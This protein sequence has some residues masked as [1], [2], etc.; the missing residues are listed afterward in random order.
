MIV[1]PAGALKAAT[2]EANIG[3]QVRLVGD[4]EGFRLEA[5]NDE[6][7]VVSAVLKHNPCDVLDCEVDREMLGKVA[8]TLK[9]DVKLT[10]TLSAVTLTVGTGKF[11]LSVLQPIPHP[12]YEPVKAGET[13]MLAHDE[14]VWVCDNLGT[15]IK[16]RQNN[17]YRDVTVFP[18]GESVDLV[19]T[20]GTYIAGLH[21]DGVRKLSVKRDLPLWLFRKDLMD[22]TLVFGADKVTVFDDFTTITTFYEAAGVP[23][24]YQELLA[25]VEAARLRFSA[26]DGATLLNC[27]KPV[28][29][30][31][32]VN[33]R[34][35]GS[36]AGGFAPCIHVS[37]MDTSDLEVGADIVLEGQHLVSGIV[38]GAAP[39][40]TSTLLRALK[41]MEGAEFSAVVSIAQQIVFRSMSRFAVFM[42]VTPVP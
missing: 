23:D 4:G 11:T 32:T 34:W 37:T 39:T 27:I 33:L 20:S 16:A 10:A 24:M 22:V 28:R 19:A 42:R 40:Y 1:F 2:A 30:N 18:S 31:H 12:T 41:A 17:P 6:M 21:L 38:E 7:C 14:W 35:Y 15:A 29:N 8:A 36:D 25:P 13:L 9:G 26:T 3:A 5:T